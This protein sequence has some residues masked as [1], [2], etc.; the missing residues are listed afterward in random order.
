MRGLEEAL[1]SIREDLEFRHAYNIAR[2]NGS[3]VY[4]VG[5]F[6]F[7]GLAHALYGTPK[8]EHD[9]D[10][11]VEGLS[12]D[13]RLPPRWYRMTNR[14]GNPKIV[15][16]TTTA[17]LI[18]LEK[19]LSIKARGLRPSLEAYLSGT[20]LT[21]QAM[22]YDVE[23]DELV[24]DVGLKALEERRVAVN[25]PFFASIIARMDGTTVNGYVAEKAASLDFLH[26]SY[27][28]THS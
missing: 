10:L 7:R 2:Q 22:A 21:I 14:F 18:P 11:L 27:Q 28:P 8:P 1:D 15:S 16:A 26:V 3:R 20:P 23:H 5:G 12:R 6:L 19:V 13:L 4:L 9:V 24:G 17:D 25:N